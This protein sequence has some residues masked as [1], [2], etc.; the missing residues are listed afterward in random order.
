MKL[1]TSFLRF[2][3]VG[4]S[5]ALIYAATT[6]ALIAWA[7]APPVATGA[8]V[9][10]ACIPPAYHTQRRFAFAADRTR[11]A[12]FPLYLATQALSLALVS[13][14]SALFVTRIFLLDTLIYLAAAAGAAVLSFLISR[15]VTFAPVPAG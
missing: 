3:V 1:S 11:R 12:A 2:L 10:L 13:G 4:G 15:F 14:V 9:W 6:S 5:F 7:G 8:L